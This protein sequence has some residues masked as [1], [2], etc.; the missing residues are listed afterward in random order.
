[1]S[2]IPRLLVILAAVACASP[3]YA[4]PFLY[5]MRTTP[6]SGT[7]WPPAYLVITNARTG[8]VVNADDPPL[9]GQNEGFVQAMTTSVDG[10]R[11]YLSVG[12][13]RPRLLIMNLV[14]NRVE[15]VVPMATNNDSWMLIP[16]PT[17]QVIYG[18]IR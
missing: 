10:K 3:A 11:L 16:D 6:P 14:T 7:I 18:P 17:G 8:E 5:S 1:M 13:V 4:Q 2:T 12:F 9:L 15:T